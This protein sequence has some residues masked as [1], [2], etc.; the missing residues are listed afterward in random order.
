MSARCTVGLR[1]IPTGGS[2]GFS[3]K[4]I[5]SAGIPI[6]KNVLSVLLNKNNTSFMYITKTGTTGMFIGVWF[7]VYVKS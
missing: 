5:S 4:K 3:N 7:K 2:L 6:Q 1:S